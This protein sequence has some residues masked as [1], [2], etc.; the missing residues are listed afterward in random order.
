VAKV[1]IARE[2]EPRSQPLFVGCA[3]FCKLV[4]SVTLILI[5]SLPS[6]AQDLRATESQ[7]EAAYLYNFGKFVTWPQ[8]QAAV[9]EFFGICIL[10]KDPFGEV[11]ESTVN[12]ES[13][14]RKK[15]KV[16]RIS[17]MQ[18]ASSCNILFISSTEANNLNA[19]LAAARALSLLTVSDIKHFA[20]RGGMI[21]LV[22]DQGK[23]RFEVNRDAVQRSHLQLSSELLKVAV[24]VVAS[25]TPGSQ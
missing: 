20:E 3:L 25:R 17:S 5:S 11:M 19:T 23:I 14:G 13:I 9:H 4:F 10:G 16:E 22:P 12:G 6:P 1:N 7:V 8:E 15:I 2:C 18:Q 21:G 24:R